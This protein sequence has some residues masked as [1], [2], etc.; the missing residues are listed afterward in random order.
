MPSLSQQQS[1]LGINMNKI[2]IQQSPVIA[3]I[4]RPNVGKS[5]LFNYLSRSKQAIVANYAG[6][7]RDRQH[8]KCQFNGQ[9]YWI[10]DTGGLVDEKHDLFQTMT[11]E[12]VNLAI[13]EADLIFF[14]VDSRDGLAPEDEFITQKLRKN[15]QPVIVLSNKSDGLDPHQAS[16]EFFQLG[17]SDVFAISAKQGHNI[18]QML[19]FVFD[20]CDIEDTRKMD[21]PHRIQFAC[22]GQPNVGKSTLVN[23]LLGENR[24]MVSNVAGT[25]RDSIAIPFERNGQAYTL[26]DT[27]GIRRRAK[28]REKIEHFSIVQ[29]LKSMDAAD[30]I[31][32]LLDAQRE[33]TEQDCQLLSLL[34]KKGCPFIWAVNKWD[35]LSQ[36]EKTEYKAELKRRTMFVDCAEP[37]YI[38]ALYGSNVGHIYKHITKT[39]RNLYQEL[40]TSSLTEILKEATER[41]PPPMRDSRRIR[42]RYAHLGGRRPFTIVIHGKQTQALAQSYIR[43]LSHFFRKHLKLDGIP[44]HIKCKSNENPYV[45]AKK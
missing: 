43:Y 2:Q 13:E 19:S 36:D 35:H 21:D 38:S 28:I 44:L 42:L 1:T 41:H 3:I 9:D 6:L 30:I 23:R 4:G 14:V 16:A 31:V 12:Q 34:I 40:S 24:V 10:I 25:T 18:N 8:A 33:I 7:T 45:G 22:I 27:A 11:Q 5:T 32:F 39:H 29:S 26:I 17:F 20:H 15:K 37:M